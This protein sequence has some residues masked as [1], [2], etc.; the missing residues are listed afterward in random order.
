MSVVIRVGVDTGAHLA[1]VVIDCGGVRPRF[2]HA[3]THEVGHF[4][5]LPRARRNRLGRE[6]TRERVIDDSDLELVRH[7]IGHVLHRFCPGVAGEVVIER[8][9]KVIPRDRFCASMASAIGDAQWIGGEV[10]ATA[11]CRGHGVATVRAA[12][13]RRRIVGSGAAKDASIAPVILAS[14]EDWPR[15][16]NEHVRDAAGLVLYR[17][18][19][20]RNLCAGIIPSP[21]VARAA[22]IRRPATARA[23]A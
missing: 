14:I 17:E 18:R 12:D 10:A 2:L 4:E 15:Q 8:V 23:P 1:I 7:A 5:D 21:A 13:W 6:T 22:V 19:A 11:W 9:R 3:E 20:S 16:S